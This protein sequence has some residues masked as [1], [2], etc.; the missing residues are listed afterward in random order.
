MHA[1][2]YQE[3]EESVK[4]SPGIKEKMIESKQRHE[5]F[6]P[7]SLVVP[8]YEKNNARS[9]SQFIGTV[10]ES[11]DVFMEQTGDLISP[12][13]EKQK[14]SCGPSGLLLHTSLPDTVI[15]RTSIAGQSS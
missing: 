9:G 3:T 13:V 5:T 12:V 1:Y 7:E 6:G 2:V 14:N 10:T 15:V 8:H 11:G 4:E